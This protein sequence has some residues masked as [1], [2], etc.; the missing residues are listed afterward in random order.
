MSST[1]PCA[2]PL[3]IV[4]VV[5]QGIWVFGFEQICVRF[6]VV[7]WDD[8]ESDGSVQAV[9]TAHLFISVEQ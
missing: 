5:S 8:F 3:R 9:F 4:V 1:S 2:V 6:G 7:G